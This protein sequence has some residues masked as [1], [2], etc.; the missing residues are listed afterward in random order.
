MEQDEFAMSAFIN[1]LLVLVGLIKVGVW[2]GCSQF[3]VNNTD[4]CV[5]GEGLVGMATC[6]PTPVLWQSEDKK[7]IPVEEKEGPLMML[8]YIANQPYFGRMQRNTVIA[9]LSK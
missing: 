2:G 7:F 8:G 9:F 6:H 1:E 5:M 3:D 4:V